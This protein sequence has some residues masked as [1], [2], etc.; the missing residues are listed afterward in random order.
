MGSAAGY[1]RVSIPTTDQMT[2]LPDS[3]LTVRIKPPSA[4]HIGAIMPVAVVL[5]SAVVQEMAVTG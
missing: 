1:R 4:A 2:A 3:S 5:R